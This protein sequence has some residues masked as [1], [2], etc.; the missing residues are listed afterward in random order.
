MLSKVSLQVAKNVIEYYKMLHKGVILNKSKG[1]VIMSQ[2]LLQPHIQCGVEDAAPYALLPGDPKRVEHAKKYLTHVREIAFNREYKSIVGEYHGVKVMV[3]S[4]GM[5]GASVGIAVE[6]LQRIGVKAM[7]RIGSCGALQKGMQLGDLLLVNG[8]VRDEG[9]SK[10][11]IDA[12]YPAIPDTELLMALIQK[13]KEKG[14]RY[15]IGKVRSHD[16]FY[17]DQEDEIDAFWSSKGILGADMESAALFVIGALR[18]V[19]TASILNTVVTYEGDLEDGINDYVSGESKTA[20][21]EKNE[22]LLALDT[23]VQWSKDEGG[24]K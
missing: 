12:I 8:A 7:I 13:A 2:T 19:K 18:G 5:G 3:I 4:T 16:S 10:T 9:A 23:L 6:E 24:L 21:G 11:Y 15:H 17:T 20:I 22:I 14:I 1:R